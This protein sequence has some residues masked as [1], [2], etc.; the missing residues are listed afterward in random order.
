M[1]NALLH[2]ALAYLAGA[3]ATLAIVAWS[4]RSR[5]LNARD[6]FV[7]AVIWPVSSGVALLMVIGFML[8]RADGIRCAIGK[9]R[10]VARWGCGRTDPHPGLWALCPWWVLVVWWEAT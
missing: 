3:F 7:L 8:L 9:P 10:N 1:N 2:A 4:D 5:V 6:A